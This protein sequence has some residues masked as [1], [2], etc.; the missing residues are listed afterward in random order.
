MNEI[1]RPDLSQ[2]PPEVRAY[3]EALEAQVAQYESDQSE[4]ASAVPQEPPDRKSV[5]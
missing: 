5:V 4:Q 3:I 2:V 1:E